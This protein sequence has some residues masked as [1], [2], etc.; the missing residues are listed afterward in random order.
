[1]DSRLEQEIKALKDLG[2]NAGNSMSK[3]IEKATS[4]KNMLP[5]EQ[6]A[7]VEKAEKDSGVMAEAL[8][9]IKTTDLDFSKWA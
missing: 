1:M 2:I 4:I 5:P 6:R 7:A 3:M 9:K 8:E